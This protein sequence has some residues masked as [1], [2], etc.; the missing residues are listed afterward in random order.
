[1][2]LCLNEK[3]ILKTK[4]TRENTGTRTP[5]LTGLAG[6]AAIHSVHV[7]STLGRYNKYL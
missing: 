2:L 3:E 7:F 1:M 5:T 6:L 4:I